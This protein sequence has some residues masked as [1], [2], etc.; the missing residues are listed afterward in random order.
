M[1]PPPPLPTNFRL[2]AAE[3][4]AGVSSTSSAAEA[5]TV[6][7]G[8]GGGGVVLIAAVTDCGGG[9]VPIGAATEVLT[10]RHGCQIKAATVKRTTTA[11]ADTDKIRV[12]RERLP[13]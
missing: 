8:G 7:G 13:A 3:I 6:G 10:C 9:V 11:A 2:V 4:S 1:V 12:R 5:V